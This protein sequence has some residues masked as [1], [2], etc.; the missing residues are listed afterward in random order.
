MVK[1]V[2]RVRIL[3]TCFVFVAAF[4]VQGCRENEQGRT[5]LYKKGTYLGKSD[6]QL[7]EAQKNA[8]RLRTSRQNLQ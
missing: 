8:L 6:R 5:L 7:T 4:A 1:S 3:A 2:G